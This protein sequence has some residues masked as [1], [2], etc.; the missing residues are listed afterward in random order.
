MYTVAD[1]LLDIVKAL[2]AD[3]VFG[4]PGDYNLNFLDHIT[5]RKDLR[6]LG[7]ANELNAAYMADGY[8]RKKGFAAFV[9]TFGVGELSALNGFAGSKAEHV[10]VLEIVGTPLTPVQKASAPIHHTFGDGNFKKFEAAHQALGFHTAHL[11]H[12]NAVEEINKLIKTMIETRQPAYLTIP[13]DVAEIQINQEIK[14]E[15]P[16]LIKE[17]ME[18]TN[19]MLIELIMEQL[20]KAKSPIIFIGH[21]LA[22][23]KLENF[24]EKFIV[25]NNLPFTNNG[26]SKGVVSESL[27]QFIGTYNGAFSKPMTKE[28][29]DQ[30]D[31]ILLLGV[32]LT[33]LVT[34]NFTQSFND[35]KTIA[36]NADHMRFFGKTENA[37]QPYHFAS[38]IQAL[39]EETISTS[40]KTGTAFSKMINQPNGTDNKLTQDFYDTAVAAFIQPEEVLFAEQGTSFLGLTMNELPNKARYNA[41][42]L[43]GSIGYTFPAMLGSQVADPTSRNILSIGEGSLQMTIQEFGFAFRENLHPIILLIENSGYTIERFIHGMDE[44]Y[45]DV[46]QLDY[47]KIPQLFGAKKSDYLLRY[48]T[49]ENELLEAFSQARENTDKLILI[50]I[51]LAEKDAPKPLRDMVKAAEAAAKVN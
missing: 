46:A 20:N 30:A 5:S 13:M 27:P 50:R 24:V 43:W 31:L 45:N 21:E 26:F 33:D 12:E 18:K 2:G 28:I 36:L 48:V 7:N 38:T 6:W 15:I 10:P 1:Y 22:R 44:S 3:E 23:F 37:Q 17:P 16:A 25:N 47:G 35:T 4:V 29:I 19:S 51:E 11:T 40:I 39:S 14:N 9:T 49:T 32:Q 34:G 8:A 41:Q 42:P